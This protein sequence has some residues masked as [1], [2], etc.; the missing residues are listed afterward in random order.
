MHEKLGSS[1]N[2]KKKSS[3]SRL[4]SGPVYSLC[5]TCNHI[6]LNWW[7]RVGHTWA[8]HIYPCV[9]KCSNCCSYTNVKCTNICWNI[10][11]ILSESAEMKTLSN[12]ELQYFWHLKWLSSW[13]KIISY[14]DKYILYH[15]IFNQRSSKIMPLDRKVWFNCYSGLFVYD[16]ERN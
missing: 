2:W 16:Q 6:H 13:L 9:L 4:R 5:L 10:L 14:V 1:K 3:R 11:R 12:E 15:F 7:V 8:N